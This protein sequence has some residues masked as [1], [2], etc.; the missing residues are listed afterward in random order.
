MIMINYKQSFIT[1]MVIVL[2]LHFI[3]KHCL[4][5]KNNKRVRFNLNNELND[6]SKQNMGNSYQIDSSDNRLDENISDENIFDENISDENDDLTTYIKH[7][8]NDKKQNNNL[9]VKDELLKYVNNYTISSDD[10]NECDYELTD[11]IKGEDL[12]HFFQIN[13]KDEY[14]FNETPTNE[15]LQM[16][17]LPTKIDIFSKEPI[18]TDD[19]N[20]ETFI[21]Q[22]KW[23]YMKESPMNGG[24]VMINIKGYDSLG[25]SDTFATFKD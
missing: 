8:V 16:N 2:I 14:T 4:L 12:S 19:A 24:D 10:S 18:H 6:Y 25:N 5:W 23:K 7:V 11:E 17:K 13:N 22:D 9:N 20:N 15:A 21:Q 3:I 1:G